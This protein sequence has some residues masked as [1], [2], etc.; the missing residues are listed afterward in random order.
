MRR[1]DLP[2]SPAAVILGRGAR[3]LS[4]CLAAENAGVMAGRITR[5]DFLD[6]VA[7]AIA[8]GLAPIDALGAAGSAPYP[9]ALTGLRG[10]NDSAFEVIHGVAREGVKYDIARLADEEEY[11]LVVI[12][13]GLAGLTAA[14][15]YRE[16]H[17]RAR[18]LILDNH[19]DFGGHARRNELMIGRRLLL[20]YGGSES[21]VSPRTEFGGSAKRMFR[22]LGFD[23]ERF[24]DE[25]VFHRT[26]Y[27]RLGLS[28]AVFF[29]REAFGRD[30]LV[31]GDP[32]VLGFDEFAPASPNSRPLDQFLADCPLSDAARAAILDLATAKRDPL[33]GQSDKAKLAILEETSYRE[34]L[35]KLCGFPKEASDFYQGRLN[36]N[37]GL[38]I[39]CIPAREAM[40]SGLPG[41][42]ALGLARE[43]KGHDSEPYIHHFPDG[44]ASLARLIVRSLV[45]AVAPGHGMDSIVTARFDY[46]KLDQRNAPVRVR[47]DATAVVVRNQSGGVAVG[48]VRKGKLHRVRGRR[49]VV[50]TYA[51]VMPH[52]VPELAAEARATLARNVKTPLVYAKALIRDWQSFV[53]LGVHNIAQPIG[54]LST[55][56]LDYPVSLGGYRF[57]RDPKEPMVVHMV[58]VPLKPNQGLDARD[59]CRLGRQWLLETPYG[60]IER[61]IRADLDRMLGGGGFDA[62]RDILAVT[63]NRWSHGYSYA[64]SSLYDD[65]E[66][67]AKAAAAAKRRIGNIVLANSDTGWDAYAHTALAEAAR[68]VRE[69]G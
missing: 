60:V 66:A 34:F 23:P 10:S 22:A 51:M 20:S 49:A 33:A 46:A 8:A 13:A 54:F 50:A 27:P 24:Y 6:G 12:G 28:R 36:D 58:H 26:L 30:A 47:L 67:D 9:P 48:Y 56:K 37:W 68:A 69:L 16:R 40:A 29:A 21:L 25:R 53:R 17:P 45:P 3:G 35:D 43:I 5:R 44:N 1:R 15:L 62:E 61:A 59:Q 38:G 39:D 2:A 18:I 65:V 55:V 42:E 52:I 32:L 11:D 41:A 64:S 7:L 4:G 63:V 57:P 31:G 19:D 14:W